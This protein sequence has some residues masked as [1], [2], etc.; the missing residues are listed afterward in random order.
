MPSPFKVPIIAPQKAFFYLLPASHLGNQSL[1]TSGRMTAIL[2]PQSFSS[3]SIIK[4]LNLH[5]F[6]T[7][8]IYLIHQAPPAKEGFQAG[9]LAGDQQIIDGSGRRPYGGAIDFLPPG[10][11]KWA[12]SFNKV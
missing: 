7:V 8:N 3:A 1:P 2:Q 10:V 9:K 6:S 5:H 12:I 11:L 4:I